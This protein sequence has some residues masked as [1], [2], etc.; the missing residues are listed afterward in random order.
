MREVVLFLAMSLD[1]YLADPQGKVDWI[2]GQEA[3]CPEDQDSYTEFVKGIDTV[4]LGWRTY[5]QIVTELS[6]G[7]WVYAGLLSYVI[8]HRQIPAQE[9]IIFTDTDPCRLVRELKEKQGKNIWICGGAQVI[10]QLMR[11]DLIDVYHLSVIP[12]ILGK[13]IRLFPELEN[14]R[15]LKLTKTSTSNGITELIYT[16]REL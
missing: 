2:S 9:E 6:P 15:K 16:R 12:A 5:E 8:T 3:D 4:I 7:E 1:G 13:G 10:R 11:E 14:E